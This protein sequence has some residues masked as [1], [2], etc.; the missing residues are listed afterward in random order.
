ME[1]KRLG[2]CNKS[3]FVVPKSF[4]GAVG[5]GVLAALSGG[6]YL[7]ATKKDFEMKTE[8]ASAAGLPQAIMTL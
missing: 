3:L 8:N 1:S 2:L 7:V 6:K 4:D 5:G